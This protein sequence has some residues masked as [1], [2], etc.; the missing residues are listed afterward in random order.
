M[1]R[2]GRDIT[3]FCTNTGPQGH[4]WMVAYDQNTGNSAVMNFGPRDETC[5]GRAETVAGLAVPG[6]TNFSSHIGSADEL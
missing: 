3:V 4:F 1:D 2:D 6:D 5:A